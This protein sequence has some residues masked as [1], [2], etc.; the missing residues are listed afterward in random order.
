MPGLDEAAFGLD[1]IEQFNL[2]LAEASR[3]GADEPECMTLATATADGRPSARMVLL[4]GVD[5]RGLV[6]FTNYESRKGRELADN[7]HAALVFHWPT[8]DRQVRVEGRVERVSAEESDAYFDARPLG[9][10]LTAIVSP[11]SA[12]VSG[13]ADLER[14]VRDLVARSRHD[15]G[16]LRRPD[17][18]GG[19]RVIPSVVEFWQSGP[20]RLHDRLRYRRLEDAR[21]LIERLAP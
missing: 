3:A 8:L 12:V 9:S 11:Q 14:R 13:R 4:R 1:P 10:R 19:Y 17:R 6:F 21:W 16:Q 7:P 5:E 2:W 18:W 20:H 15:P